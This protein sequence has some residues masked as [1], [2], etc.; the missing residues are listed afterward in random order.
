ML[1]GPSLLFSGI[2]NTKAAVSVHSG[3]PEDKTEINQYVA[4]KLYAVMTQ[5]FLN[6]FFHSKAAA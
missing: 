2:L 3:S 1:S 4:G 6:K 5:L